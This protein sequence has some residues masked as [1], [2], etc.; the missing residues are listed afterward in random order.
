M[1]GGWGREGWAASPPPRWEVGF[2]SNHSRPQTVLLSF[3]ENGTFSGPGTF[4]ISLKYTMKQCNKFLSSTA[5]RG[6]EICTIQ[7]VLEGHMSKG[8]GV[9]HCPA[10]HRLGH[11][12]LQ[13]F[14]QA[15]LGKAPPDT[16]VTPTHTL[17]PAGSHAALS[18][19]PRGRGWRR[20]R[21][22]GAAP[23]RQSGP[24]AGHCLARG[25]SPATAG[26]QMTF[27][28]APSSSSP[29]CCPL[30]PRSHLT[31]SPQYAP[32]L[33]V[34]CACCLA[35]VS[36]RPSGCQCGG[37]E[38]CQVLLVAASNQRKARAASG[39]SHGPGS[40]CGSTYR[41]KTSRGCSVVGARACR[42]SLPGEISGI[43]DILWG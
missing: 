38:G 23:R 6:G 8:L 30:S 5:P 2:G 43:P 33:C 27:P 21:E 1:G 34:G 29:P 32:P 9:L 36:G 22:H 7:A 3:F 13:R 41:K 28:T 16:V 19:E 12:A 40:N 11:P 20:H 25:P 39:A 31:P 18:S 10:H 14:A 26:P 24:P 37:S 4:G 35:I 42:F 15:V 17:N